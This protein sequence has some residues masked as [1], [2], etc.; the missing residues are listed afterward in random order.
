MLYI[1]SA[2][3]ASGEIPLTFTRPLLQQ[4]GH[5]VSSTVSAHLKRIVIERKHFAPPLNVVQ[6][7]KSYQDPDLS[8]YK[9]DK[10]SD[11]LYRVSDSKK[12]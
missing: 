7:H 11:L 5:Y 2:F 9:H 12:K 3:G 8:S 6:A 4:A 1:L 10:D